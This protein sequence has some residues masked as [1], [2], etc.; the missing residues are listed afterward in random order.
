LLA[1]KKAVGSYIVFKKKLDEHGNCI[2]F[3]VCIVAKSFS[4]VT[5][6]DFSETFSSVAKFTI[7]WIFF[8]LTVYLDFDIHQ[9]DVVTAYLQGNLDKEI[10][11]SI[12]N[13]VSQ[14]G[15]GE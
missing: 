13:R 11:I 4:Q 6:K 12:S 8:V 5:S 7:L 14:F 2:K 3:K 10:Y 1:G 9:V 15:L